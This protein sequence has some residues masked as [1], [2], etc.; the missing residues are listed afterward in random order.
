MTAE[1]FN[2]VQDAVGA[3]SPGMLTIGMFAS[4][5]LL[6]ILGVS[7][8]YAMGGLAVIF[9]VM[10]YG[11]GGPFVVISATFQTMWSILLAA[12]PLFVFIGVALARSKIAT[13]LYGAFYIWSG[14]SNG[15]LLVGSAGF[16]AVLSA[17]TGNCA[18][19][20]I[21][22]GLVGM[23]AM[24]KH[25]YNRR[26]VL[27]TIGSAGTL[28]VLIPPSITLIII[29][30]LTGQSVG[31]LFMGG[32]VVGLIVLFAFIAYLIILT[33]MKPELAPAAEFSTPLRGKILAF[34]SVFFPLMIIVSVLVAIFAGVATPTEAAAV[35]AVAVT[36]A[37]AVR[38]ELSLKFI[39]EVSYETATVTG[40]VVWIIF[41]ATAFV[42]VY[43]GGGGVTFMQTLLLGLDVSPIVL[44]II[45]QL[46]ALLL[47]MFLDPVGIILLIL[48]IFF[49]VTQ[50]LGYDAI[51]FC[52][53]FQLNLCIGYITPPFGYNLFYLKTLSPE[54]PILEIYRS[55]IPFIAIMLAV[56]VT[57]F[58]FPSIIID[59]TNMLVE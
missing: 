43:A 3:I 23:P 27:G 58:V 47:G 40:M 36:L 2:N 14:K 57:L 13:D 29:G 22:T 54:T 53:L 34:K 19:A 11:A 1:F 50:S 35:G 6:V 16:A 56:G 46:V 10:I 15:G 48:P 20:T 38:G 55:V 31:K 41:G 32:L 17:M 37:V 28:G 26:L 9:S 18:A 45:M 51:W 52:I 49:P 25:K 59:L 7:L 4:L 39:K 30:M 24:E 21:T 33:K 12:V 5:L 42:N 8:S 44:I